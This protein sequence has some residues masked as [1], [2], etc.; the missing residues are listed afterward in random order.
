MT[1][2]VGEIRDALGC[3]TDIA[4]AGA[5]GIRS[6]NISN[7]KKAGRIPDNQIIAIGRLLDRRGSQWPAAFL[8]LYRERIP[9]PPSALSAAVA[10]A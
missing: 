7:W 6:S 1:C 10:V 8:E 9:V 4:L 2:V 3:E 5:L